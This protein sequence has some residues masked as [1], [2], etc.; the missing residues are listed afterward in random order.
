MRTIPSA[1]VSGFVSAASSGGQ[2]V[3]G[4][5]EGDQPVRWVGIGAGEP[6]LLAGPGEAED[7]AN[8]GTVVGTSGGAAVLWTSTGQR[9]TVLDV[10]VESNATGISGWTFLSANAISDDARVIAGAGAFGGRSRGW[11]ARLPAAE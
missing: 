11:V 2:F 10:L 3:V 5:L 7:V 4:T 1:G 9:R 8:D 6:E